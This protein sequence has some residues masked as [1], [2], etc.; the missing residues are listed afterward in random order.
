MIHLESPAEPPHAKSARMRGYPCTCPCATHQSWGIDSIQPLIKRR[1]VVIRN[2]INTYLIFVACQNRR[3][4]GRCRQLLRILYNTRGPPFA[5]RV[6]YDN[7]I[8]IV[9]A[10]KQISTIPR[11][12]DGHGSVL[13]FDLDLSDAVR[14]G[15]FVSV[16]FRLAVRVRKGEQ[17]WGNTDIGL[18]ED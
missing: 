4:S 1:R 7:E 12:A 16:R 15:E 11:H 3:Q 17:K 2:I 5:V 18:P 9:I 14:Y 6:G 8:R 10:I 13:L